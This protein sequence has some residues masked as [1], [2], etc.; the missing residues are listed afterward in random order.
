MQASLHKSDTLAVAHPSLLG[1][2]SIPASPTFAPVH[3]STFPS[4][5]FPHCIHLRHA[6]WIPNDPRGPHKLAPG[7]STG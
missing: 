2:G 4:S 7:T 1:L 6:A 3:S 5:T